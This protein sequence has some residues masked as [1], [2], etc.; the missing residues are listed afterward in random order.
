MTTKPHTATIPPHCLEWLVASRRMLLDDMEQG[1]QVRD[2][3]A[4][5]PVLATWTADGRHPVNLSIKG[6]GLIPSDDL[7][8]DFT[9]ECE[10]VFERAR[11]ADWPQSLPERIDT[12]RRLYADVR[13]F[14]PR[15]LGGL[16]IFEGRT[17]HNLKSNPSAS[18]LFM[19]MLPRPG[20]VSYISFQVNA[21]AEI[22]TSVDPRHRF[23]LAARRLFEYDRFHLPQIEYHKAYI[24][25]VIEVLDKSPFIKTVK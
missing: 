20:R 7:L 14:D 15:F 17:L 5:L 21:E 2:F 10:R 8:E 13:H 1:R 18:L 11:E 24:F 12:L 23:L 19:G 6:I 4:H 22:L 3:P 25:R 9:Q 16:E